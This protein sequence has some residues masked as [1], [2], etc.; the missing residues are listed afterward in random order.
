M[1]DT[2]QLCKPEYQS[3]GPTVYFVFIVIGPFESSQAI[4]LTEEVLIVFFQAEIACVHNC[5]ANV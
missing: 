5:T 4:S 1:E 3:C 2:G